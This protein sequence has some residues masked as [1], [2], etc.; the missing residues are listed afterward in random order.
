L[1]LGFSHG[2][3]HRCE[4]RC[5]HPYLDA[6]MRRLARTIYVRKASA[7][8]TRRAPRRSRV[9]RRSPRLR[10]GLA[11]AMSTR[12]HHRFRRIIFAASWLLAGLFMLWCRRCLS[13]RRLARRF[14]GVPGP[15]LRV[16]S[17]PLNSMTIA[18]RLSIEWNKVGTQRS[19]Q[20][21]FANPERGRGLLH[22]PLRVAAEDQVRTSVVGKPTSSIWMAANLSST[23]SA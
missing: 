7:F 8:N 6:S 18:I 22:R 17:R 1:Q 5:S 2:Q 21:S 23:A 16:A 14:S 4:R 15:H 20:A 9:K 10:Y 3:G 12:L 11:R 13:Y 19:E